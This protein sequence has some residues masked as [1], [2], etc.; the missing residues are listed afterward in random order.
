VISSNYTCVPL[1]SCPFRNRNRVALHGGRALHR[2]YSKY[3]YSIPIG[4]E[5]A[6]IPVTAIGMSIIA[7]PALRLSF[8]CASP[9]LHLPTS[10][11]RTFLP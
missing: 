9:P 8:L 2:T 1:L 3:M 6:L 7:H 11:V 5:Y 10:A 4:S